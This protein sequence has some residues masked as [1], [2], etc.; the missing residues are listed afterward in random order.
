[1][2]A[3]S[4][5]SKTRSM[6]M[7]FASE[8]RRGEYFAGLFILGCVS[9]ITS[10][11]IEAINSLGWANAIFS[12][13]QI[14]VLIWFS[15]IVGITLIFQDRAAGINSLELGLGAAFVVLIILPIGTL[16]WIA[17]TGLSIYI[18][19][20]RKTALARRGASILLATTVPMLWSRALYEFF[21]NTI[22]G[23]DASLVSWLLHTHR[24]GNVVEFADGSGQLVVFRDCSSLA[25][26][27]LAFLCWV[28]LSRMVSHKKSVYDVFWCLLACA[29]VVTV[30]VSRMTIL[31]LSEWHYATFHNQAGDAVANIIILGLIISI[32]A[33]GVRRELF[34]RT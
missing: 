2:I 31:G 4:H 28:T 19:F 29:A 33:L 14:S 26:V 27:S 1:M 11:V 12:T 13:F 25:N 15:C 17:V 20:R 23:I 24:S 9:G 18:L 32:C 34:E 10:R 22:L 3:R 7:R 16:S 6:A 5:V 21:A 8:I 30:N